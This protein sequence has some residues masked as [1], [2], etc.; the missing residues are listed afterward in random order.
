MT[1]VEIKVNLDA[2]CIRCGKGGATQSGVC[3][4]C[5][6]KALQNGE[7]DHI[8]KKYKSRLTQSRSAKEK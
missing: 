2:K 4:P 6:N 7:F 5:I 8:L 3:L 1:K